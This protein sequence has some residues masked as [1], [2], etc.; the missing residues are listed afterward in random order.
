MAGGALPNSL[1]ALGEV[2]APALLNGA[3]RGPSMKTIQLLALALAYCL[4]RTATAHAGDDRGDVEVPVAA[5]KVIVAGP[6]AIHA[7][8]AFSGAK[9]FVIAAGAASDGDCQAAAPTTAGTTLSAD[10]V[11]TLS[12]GA[13]QVACVA[14]TGARQ[15]ELLW[16]ARKYVPGPALPPDR[17]DEVRGPAPAVPVAGLVTIDD[18]RRR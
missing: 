8:S 18:N 16:H 10:K 9:L 3:G 13:G 6:V 1:K 4:C 17:R 12:V 7:Y 15:I 5:A 11:E 14:S 2:M